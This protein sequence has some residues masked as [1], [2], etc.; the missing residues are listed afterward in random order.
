MSINKGESRKPTLHARNRN[1]EQYDLTKMVATTPELNAYI[2]PNKQGQPSINFSDPKAIKVLNRAILQHYYG[3]G[4]WNFPDGYLCPPIPGRAEY[5][6]RVADL[7]AQENNGNVPTGKRVQCLDVGTGASCIY[8][9]I[10]TIEYQWQFIASDISKEAIQSAQQIIEKNAQLRDCIA[11]RH[12]SSSNS[13]FEGILQ[14]DERITL[15]I[16]N[17]PFH[18]S[19]E[20]ATKGTR[21][22]VKNLT[23]QQTTTPTLNFG[24]I[25][26]ELIYIGGEYQFI[27]NM[28]VESRAI[29]SNCLW[30]TCLVSKENNLKRLHRFLQQQ[31]PTDIQVLP[32]QTGNKTSRILA[33]TY[34]KERNRRK[35]LSA[36]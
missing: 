7:L 15:S 11:L 13:I 25:K 1:K 12:Q 16:C 27:Q 21:R 35:W 19:V 8:P 29:A 6:H 36:L 14:P 23:G 22:K 32:I 33:W 17:P 30:F 4:Y 34:L 2:Q 20:E 28:M 5:I 31:R 3:I 26:D 24:G 18:A 10:G 9:V